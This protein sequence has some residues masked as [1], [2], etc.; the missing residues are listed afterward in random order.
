MASDVNVYALR[1]E[2]AEMVESAYEAHDMKVLGRISS[3]TKHR[4][5]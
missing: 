5:T 1:K 2:S 3:H 4:H